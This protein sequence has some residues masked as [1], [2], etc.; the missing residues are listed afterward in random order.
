MLLTALGFFNLGDIF[1]LNYLKNGGSLLINLAASILF[2]CYGMIDWPV[3]IC[4]ALG[5][6]VGA[7]AMSGLARRLGAKILRKIVSA[8]G[9]AIAAT[10]LIRQFL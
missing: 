10:M 5:G 6:C 8:I 1:R 2:I 9:I 4:I 3:A 7:L